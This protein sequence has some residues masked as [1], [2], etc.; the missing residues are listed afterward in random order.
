MPTLTDVDKEWEPCPECDGTGRV[1]HKCCDFEVLWEDPDWDHE[2][3]RQGMLWERCRHCG[4]LQKCRYQ[5][6]AGTG[7]DNVVMAVGEKQRRFEFPIEE[8]E[9]IE[10]GEAPTEYAVLVKE[11]QDATDE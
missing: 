10:R 7:S 4:S 5:W 8:A 11:V 6:D 1:R 3:S 2:D 9:R